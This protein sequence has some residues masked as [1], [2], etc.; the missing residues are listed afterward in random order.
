MITIM[1][2]GPCERNN[3]TEELTEIE[4]FKINGGSQSTGAG[5]GKVT[6]N[7]FHIT[8]KTDAASPELF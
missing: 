4:L 5:A 1:P 8:K 2:A 6:F 7:P 3:R